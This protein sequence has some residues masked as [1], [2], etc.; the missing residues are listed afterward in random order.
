MAMRPG[1]TVRQ[2]QRLA[3]TPGMRTSLAMLRMPADQLIEEIAREAAENP[4]LVV[5]HRTSSAGFAGVDTTEA[6]PV[7][8]FVSLA[9]QISQQR[10]EPQVASA[11]LL[12]ARELREDGYLDISLDELADESGLPVPDLEA[13]LAALQTCDPPG[14]GARTLQECLALKL[15]DTGEKAELARAIVAR[16]DD[17]AEDRWARVAKAV[18]VA[19]SE[20]RRIGAVLR[21][22]TSVPVER[23]DPPIV[24]RIP[25]I[26]VETGPNGPVPR[27]NPDVFPRLTAMA[28]P[29]AAND[30]MRAYGVRAAAFLS[31]FE[32]RSRTLLR[33]AEAIMAAQPGFFAGNTE[34]LGPLSRA[35]VSG[36]LA[37]HVSTLA[38]AIQ[39]KS[40]AFGGKT[41]P[42]GDF[43]SHALPQSGGV[44]SVFEVQRRIRA[45]VASEDSVAPL[46]DEAIAAQLKDEGVDIARRTVAKYRKCMRIPSS[47][48]RRRRKLPKAAGQRRTNAV[49]ASWNRPKT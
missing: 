28:V 30:R 11:A 12:L 44:I 25:D 24:T 1:L 23:Q 15:I 46:A 31:A 39:D 7:G 6:G 13:G 3:M 21:S 14:V 48:E 9:A 32:A 8:L 29:S 42:L 17:I 36:S 2:T 26:I 49:Q 22:L 18:G 40:L 37:L 45:L 43:F 16:L 41:Y 33:I 35:E 19:A 47:F 38:R 27:M 5:T 34:S 20:A 10:L 4:L